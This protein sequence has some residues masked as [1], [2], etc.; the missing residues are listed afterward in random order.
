MLE[1]E[2]RRGRLAPALGVLCLY[3]RFFDMIPYASP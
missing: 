1:A 3:E 2:L